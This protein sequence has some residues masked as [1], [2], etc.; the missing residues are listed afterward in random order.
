MTWAKYIPLLAIADE[1]H[2]LEFSGSDNL[3]DRSFGSLNTGNFINSYLQFSKF[4]KFLNK[5]NCENS[6]N[7]AHITFLYWV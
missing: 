5:E 4:T 2:P 6:Q 1:L 7:A 3:F